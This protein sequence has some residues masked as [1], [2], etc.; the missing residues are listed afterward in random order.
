MRGEGGRGTTS[1]LRLKLSMLFSRPGL[2]VCETG[3]TS[4]DDSGQ[5][6]RDGERADVGLLHVE[7][8]SLS[9]SP[10]LLPLATGWNA[11]LKENEAQACA[12]A[13]FPSLRLSSCGGHRHAL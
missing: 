5:A 2:A 10:P 13:G 3:T 6:R 4:E 7:S 8:N 1:A 12:P 11:P 9:W